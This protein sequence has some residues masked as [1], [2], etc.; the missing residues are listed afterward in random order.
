[1]LVQPQAR[2]L[3]QYRASSSHHRLASSRAAHTPQDARLRVRRASSCGQPVQCASSNTAAWRQQ[4]RQWP[5]VGVLDAIAEADEDDP[6]RLEDLLVAAS[7]DQVVL[8]I[9]TSNRRRESHA[10]HAPLPPP[11]VLAWRRQ[12]PSHVPQSRRRKPPRR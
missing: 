6:V 10:L 11:T 8:T 3:L 9:E 7:V 4:R 1:M 12:R 2:P 5:A